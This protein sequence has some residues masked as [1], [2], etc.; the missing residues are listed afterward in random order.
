MNDVVLDTASTFDPNYKDF[1]PI[2]MSE[3][4]HGAIDSPTPTPPTPTL[5]PKTEMM[6]SPQASPPPLL[7]VDVDGASGSNS[8]LIAANSV[9]SHDL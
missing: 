5:T 1:V 7:D 9:R 3:G 2:E 8:T 4:F 6:S